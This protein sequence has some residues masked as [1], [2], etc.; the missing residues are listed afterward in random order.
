MLRTVEAGI[1]CDHSYT[2]GAGVRSGGAR[3][4]AMVVEHVART[5]DVRDT[6]CPLSYVGCRT[7]TDTDVPVFHHKVT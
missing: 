3:C 7:G 1:R 5:D 6:V 4:Q 2:I